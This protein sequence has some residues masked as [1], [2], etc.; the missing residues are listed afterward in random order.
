MDHAISFVFFF[1]AALDL[2]YSAWAPL[3]AGH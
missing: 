2:R 3:V 1:L